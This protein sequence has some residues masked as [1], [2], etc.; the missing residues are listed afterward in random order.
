MTRDNFSPKTR[1][2]LALSVNFQCA[3]PG[4]SIVTYFP[5]KDLQGSINIGNAAHITAAAEGGPRYDENLT[6]EQ[7]KAADNGV[8]L[9]ANDARLID[10]DSDAFPVSLLR[11]WQYNKMQELRLNDGQRLRYGTASLVDVNREVKAFISL[12]NNLRLSI[13]IQSVAVADE[14]L[15]AIWNILSACRWQ[16]RDGATTYD[17]WQAGSKYHAQDTFAVAI[18]INALE[19][20]WRLY[21]SI[22]NYNGDWYRSN[23]LYYYLPNGYFYNHNG[24]LDFRGDKIQAQKTLSLAEERLKDFR[25]C[26]SDLQRYISEPN[27]RTVI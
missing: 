24:F 3:R 13:N 9:C 15:R 7:R 1:F 14:H 20:L 25:K 12:C 26:I 19:A 4:C 2:E 21:S 8:H 11:N 18:Q 6:P 23:D 16:G 22:K 5:R 27:T 10:A 17:D